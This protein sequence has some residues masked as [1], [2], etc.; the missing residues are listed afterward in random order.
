MMLQFERVV[1]TGTAALDSGIGDTAL[2]TFNGETYLYSM[3]GVAGG[4]ASWRLTDGAGPQLVD[5]QHYAG[6]I[7]FQVD[8]SGI[9]VTLGGQNHLILDVDAATGLVSY[10]L[11]TNGTIGDL[12]E[13][14]TLTGGGDISAAV[15]VSFGASD[16]LTL[17]HTDSGQIGSY[18]VNADGSLSV[19]GTVTGRADVLQSL[20]SGSGHFVIAAD[21]ASNAITTFSVDQTLGT[22][23]EVQGNTAFETLGINAPT[24]VEVVQAYGKS[25]VVVASA[26]SNSLSVMQLGSDGRLTPTDHVLDSL[27]TRFESVQDLALIEVNGR[28][29]VV[30]GGGDDGITLFTMTQDGQLIY[31]DSYADTLASG[32]QNVE[33]LSVAHVGDELQIFAASQQDAGL[34]QLS[35]SVADLGLVRQGFGT[36]SGTAGDDM[37]RGGVLESTLNGGAGD[38]IL[39]TGT[40]PTT[41][42]G[43]SGAD[44]FF[45][46]SGSGQTTINDFQVGTDR[47]DLS[48]FWLLRTPAQLDFTTTAQGAR[49]EYRGDSIDITSASAGPLTST[50]VFGAGFVGPDHVPVIISNGPDSNSAPGVLGPVSLDSTT[51]NPALAGAE[52]RFTPD[53]G[54]AITAQANADGEFDLDIP[55]GAFSGELEIVKSYSL[56]SG[57]ITALDALQVLRIAIGLEPTFGPP[58]AENLIAADINRDGMVSAIDALIVLQNAV[59]QTARHAAEWVFLDDDADLSGITRT[60]V[61]YETGAPVTVI[62]GEFAVDMTSILLGN[63]EAA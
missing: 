36:V 55:D 12:Q 25:W 20:Q 28:V 51:D 61:S 16:L 5:Q 9:P 2:K 34:T 21:T 52:I 56:A 7:T 39:I 11:N 33:T 10:D 18:H 57:E 26:G 6:T 35:A 17:A 1:A 58:T 37:L 54:S 24:A 23:S 59:G 43:G 49:I 40:S 44:I 4:I 27:H 63:I 50:D 3:T 13:T 47:L 29:F 48:D 45:I 30:A 14:G 42:T 19:A 8:R 22:L 38:D 60:N 41:M 53:G 15:Q 31:L 62:D 32:L 46:R